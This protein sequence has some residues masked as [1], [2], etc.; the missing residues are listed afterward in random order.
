MKKVGV[1][2]SMENDMLELKKTIKQQAEMIAE[3]DV[4]LQSAKVQIAEREEWLAQSRRQLDERDQ[5]QKDTQKSLQSLE[6][7]ILQYDQ[8]FHALGIYDPVPPLY[9]ST[10]D[11]ENHLRTGFPYSYFLGRKV[12]LIGEKNSSK[13]CVIFFT[14]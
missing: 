13:T 12:L 4:W 8:K 6:D 1:V 5:W 11:R 7:R 2:Q 9:T 14:I 3:R 10:Q